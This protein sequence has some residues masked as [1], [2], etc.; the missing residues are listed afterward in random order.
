MS[1]TDPAGR[2]GPRAQRSALRRR[3]ILDAAVSTIGER[4]YGG[5]SLA[6]IADEVGI[7]APSLLHHFRNKEQLLTE[8]LAYR[9]DL[10][11]SYHGEAADLEGAPLLEHLV[12]TAEENSRRRGL[13][14][15]Y[16]VLLGESITSNHPGKDFFR[17]RF[18]GLREMVRDAVLE[19]IADPDV[20]EEDVLETASAIIA[21][22]DGIQFQFL[23]EPYAVDMAGVTERTVRALL[24]D[25]RAGGTGRSDA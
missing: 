18:A 23:L 19:A 5:A 10:S 3:E 20:P 24:A 4:G 13:T 9:D 25:L 15:L 11:R 16:A 12:D 14:Q 6:A 7:A 22:M 2:L 17:E 8:V 1:S 21:V